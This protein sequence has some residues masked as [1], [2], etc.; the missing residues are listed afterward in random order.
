MNDTLLN[1]LMRNGPTKSDQISSEMGISQPTVSRLILSLGDRVIR[2]G[3]SKNTKYAVLRKIRQLAEKIKVFKV[4]ESG[5]CSLVENLFAVHP[6]GFVFD[7]KS[8]GWPLTH[9]GQLYFDTIPYFILDSRPQGF[10]GRNFARLHS[11]ILGVPED[12]Q[13]WNDDDI[14]VAMAIMGNDVPGDIILGESSYRRF[15]EANKAISV[16]SEADIPE[17]YI[18]MAEI[19]MTSGYTGSS[20]AGEFPKFSAIRSY[21]GKDEHILVKFSGHGSSSAEI[22]WADLLRCESHAAKAI[23]SHLNIDTVECRS[24]AHGGRTFLEVVRFDRCG[25][26]GR[27]PMCSLTSIDAE[28]I[29]MGDPHWDVAADKMLSLRLIDKLT[30]ES[31]R[32]LW[33]F[34]KLIGNTDMHAGN[35][36]FRPTE[37]GRLELTPSYDMLPMRYAPFRGGEVPPQ[38]DIQVFRPI[39]GNE[40]LYN[41]AKNAAIAFWNTVSSD[42]QIS[43]EFRNIA[44][45]WVNALH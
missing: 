25:L 24:F 31:M 44:D 15:E 38:T 30:A 43:D 14:I 11:G 41:S 45:A 18:H 42:N 19:A 40:H 12:P 22:R 2:V 39:P 17:R 4:D 32:S 5:H 37:A 34:G 21:N 28:F 35:I 10:M 13:R 26:Y 23:K 7:A 20:A 27:K 9:K 1:L 3:G 6:H 8:A 33:F 36:S 29:D 16:I